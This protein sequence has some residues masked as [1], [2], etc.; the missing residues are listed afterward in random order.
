MNNDTTNFQVPRRQ[1]DVILELFS[2]CHFEASKNQLC[3]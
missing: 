1:E 3:Q 2:T